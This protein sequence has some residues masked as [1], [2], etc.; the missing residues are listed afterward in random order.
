MCYIFEYSGGLLG[1]LTGGKEQAEAEA[2]YRKSPRAS[3]SR[4]GPWDMLCLSMITVDFT[5][6]HDW[7]SGWVMGSSFLTLLSDWEVELL[8]FLQ[9]SSQMLGHC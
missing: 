5:A 4:P 6:S 7:T 9:V 3:E 1:T 2:G 8:P